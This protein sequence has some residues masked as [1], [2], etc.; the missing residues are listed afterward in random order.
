MEPSPWIRFN[1]AQEKPGFQIRQTNCE[2][3]PGSKRRRGGS[4]PRQNSSEERLKQRERERDERSVNSSVRS[5]SS[6]SEGEGSDPLQT[7]PQRHSQLGCSPP[8]FLPRCN[9]ALLP[10]FNFS[11]C[12]INLCIAFDF[13]LS[14]SDFF[15]LQADALRERFETNKHVVRPPCSLL[16]NFPHSVFV[17][18]FVCVSIRFVLNLSI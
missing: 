14:I 3:K 12:P 7:S 8:P 2:S 18:V 16:F 13:N 10:L 1:S 5:S 6:S 15:L 4:F 11:S 9:Y 17:V